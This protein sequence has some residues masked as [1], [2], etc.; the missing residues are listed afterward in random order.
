MT[1]MVRLLLENSK[2]KTENSLKLQPKSRIK[3]T[4]PKK[5]ANQPGN[6][7]ID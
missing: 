5:L 1:L 2:S 7:Q 3:D 6:W 4:N